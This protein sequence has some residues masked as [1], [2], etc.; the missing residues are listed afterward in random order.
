MHK[1][2]RLMAI[3]LIL[4]K[5]KRVTAKELSNK[6]EVDIRTIY[7]DMQ[8]LSEMNIPIVSEVGQDG[9]YY[10]ENKYFI[11]PVMFNK[12]EIFSLMLSK[13]VIEEID[14]PG[15]S[16]YIKSGFLKIESVMN[17][18][19]MNSFESMEKRIKF[20]KK[21]KAIPL[22]DFKFFNTIKSALENDYKI[23][24]KYFSIK[25]IEVIEIIAEPYGLIF[26]EDTWKVVF[27]CKEYNSIK[28]IDI[29]S[30]TNAELVDEKFIIPEDFNVDKYYCENHCVLKCKGE[31]YQYV[32][33]KFNKFSYY[34]IK[35]Y[36][37]FNDAEIM[38]EQ[39][40]Y[41]LNIKSKNPEAYISLAFRFYGKFEILEPPWLRQN[42]IKELDKLYKIYNKKD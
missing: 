9:G 27:F 4:N 41:I 32:K 35:D 21:D 24:I 18:S 15:Y 37:Y 42:Y 12:D 16:E 31:N 28:S 6:F 26:V 7:R 33:L 22:R 8:A 14:I 25:E 1:V 2:D 38:K 34:S 23:K 29:N 20:N 19:I 17:D 5:N 3:L 30:I 39:E 13:K 10:L 11:P 36:I 40:N